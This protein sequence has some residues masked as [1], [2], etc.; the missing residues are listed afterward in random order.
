MRKNIWAQETCH[1][2]ATKKHKNSLVLISVFHFKEWT[3]L[4]HQTTVSMGFFKSCY[5]HRLGL[6][7][8]LTY[9]KQD[10]KENIKKLF[11]TFHPDFY[12]ELWLFWEC[13]L[14]ITSMWTYACNSDT[15][16]WSQITLHHHLAEYQI[17][18]CS[19]FNGFACLCFVRFF[20]V[21][22]LYRCCLYTRE[23]AQHYLRK[24]KKCVL[25]FLAVGVLQSAFS[26]L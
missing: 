7:R 22:I 9:I 8:Y 10:L 23:C 2:S 20:Q 15:S 1:I 3:L 21:T 6:R 24:H 14:P 12:K 4:L 26:E 18:A 19:S 25:V 16:S 11:S 17:T 5:E 13:T